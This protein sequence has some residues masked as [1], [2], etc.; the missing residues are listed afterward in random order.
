[1]SPAAVADGADSGDAVSAADPSAG[2][3]QGGAVWSDSQPMPVDKG[4]ESERWK[5]F[6]KN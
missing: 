6:R 3:Q 4:K 5:F 2:Q 1:M